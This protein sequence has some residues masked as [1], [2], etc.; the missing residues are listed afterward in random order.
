MSG[1]PK[2]EEIIRGYGRKRFEELVGRAWVILHEDRRLVGL[3]RLR[4]A[5]AREACA[6]AVGCPV[7]TFVPPSG[8]WKSGGIPVFCNELIAACALRLQ[9]G[10][11][12]RERAE[13][14]C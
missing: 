9:L 10:G 11:Y 14:V 5:L 13:R 2:R 3:D 6:V 12:V 1:E 4:L 8:T 7:R